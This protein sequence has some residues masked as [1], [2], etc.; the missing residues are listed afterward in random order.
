MV[1]YRLAQLCCLAIL[2]VYG[3]AFVIS[4]RQDIN[5]DLVDAGKLAEDIPQINQKYGENLFQ[6]DIKLSGNVWN[7]LRNESYRWTFPIPYI[8]AD[9]LDLNAKGVI[10]QSFEM[11]RLKSCI[12][13]KPYEGEASFIHFQ[14]FG[15]CWSMV[16]RLP[17][18]QDLSIGQGCDHK[19]VVEH[20]ILHA[21]GFYHEQSRTDRDDYV[22]IW[23]N[24]ITDGLQHNF[25]TYDDGFITDLNT[26]YDYESV[27]HYGPLS[28]NKNE[29]VPTI[30]AKIPAFNNII[31]QR[32]DLSALDLERLNRMYSCT[33]PH[34]LLDQCSFEFINICGMIQGTTDDADWV[35]QISSPGLSDDHTLVGRCRDAGY[36]MHFTTSAGLVDRTALL[37]SRILYPKRTEQCLQ[38]FYKINGSPQDRLVIWVRLDD[39]TGNVRTMKKIHT[40]WGDN[41]HDWKFGQVNLNVNK[42]FR[43]VFQGI[44]GDDKTA[45]GGIS[46]DDISLMETPCPHAVWQIRNFSQILANTV[47]GDRIVSPRFYSPE[48]YGIGVGLY[49]HGQPT[50]TYNG[51]TGISFHMASGEDDAVLEWPALNRQALITVFDQDPD[52][53]QR[54]SS[55]RSF[56]TSTSQVIESMN[57]ISRWERPS[58]IGGFDPSCNCNRTADYGWATFI[59]HT[60][61]NRRNFLKNDDLIIFLNFNDL[62]YLINSEVPIRAKPEPA[63]EEH[64]A[65]ADRRKRALQ[66]SGD[67]M[68][69]EAH[70]MP[71]DVSC[72]PNPCLNGGACVMAKGRASCRCSS[73]Q[74][75]FYSGEQCESS[76]MH[77]HVIGMMIGG[78]AGTI[79]LTVSI[80]AVISRR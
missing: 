5:D 35:H 68:N 27:M 48:G 73:S 58:I 78:L 3:T 54:M 67:V 10:L 11:F 39:G 30:T 6:G 43:Y 26:P 55:S 23:W 79:M 34:T 22:E 17:Q 62:T 51:Y 8:L 28:F 49:P 2:F 46:V 80:I 64:G 33:T 76:Q 31:G 12:D 21:L 1:S 63:V 66:N 45:S 70:L 18:G 24:E 44:Q 74:A 38:F 20:E 77:S 15:G 40:L 53:T 32:L 52:T 25:N 13:F 14:K 4:N 37:E 60:H 36:F 50:S 29:N 71:L 57:N 69:Y 9:N 42:K 75:F 47:K 56:T 16:G 61:L 65:I 41:D 72:D 59:S 7:A 19:A